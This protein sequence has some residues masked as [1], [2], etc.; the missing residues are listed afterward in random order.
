MSD[1]HT[2]RELFETL[3]VF[4]SAAEAESWVIEGLEHEVEL[5]DRKR[6]TK[7]V[8]AKKKVEQDAIKDSILSVLASGE[9]MRATAIADSLADG[10]TVQ[11]VSAL[12]RQMVKDGI[13]T[14]TEDKKVATFS[15]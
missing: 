1:K 9:S 13:V 2:K 5:L 6:S 11:R 3:I 14:R 4:A 15:L 7:S 8:D 12:L 10:T